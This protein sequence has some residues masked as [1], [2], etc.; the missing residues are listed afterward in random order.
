MYNMLP[1]LHCEKEKKSLVYNAYNTILMG[2]NM[3]IK[4]KKNYRN[5][6]PDPHPPSKKKN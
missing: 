2:E 1:V 4:R 5:P 3:V 6:D